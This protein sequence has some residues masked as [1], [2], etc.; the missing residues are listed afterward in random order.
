[1]Q[2][3]LAASVQ[4]LCPNLRRIRM[5]SHEVYYC[6]ETA[7]IKVHLAEWISKSIA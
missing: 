3:L 4:N 6:S 2:R 7:V 5:G 1:M